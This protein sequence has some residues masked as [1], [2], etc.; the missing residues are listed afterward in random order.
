MRV[1]VRTAVLT[2][3]L[4]AAGVV[5]ALA[6][7][8][9]TFAVLPFQVNGPASY[10]H[11][12]R[13]IP[14]MLTSRLY[15]KDHFVAVD[16]SAYE[17]IAVPASSAEAATALQKVGVDYLVYGSTTIIGD[18]SSVDVHVVGSDGTSWPR[19]AS[20][21]VDQMI[22]TLRNLAEAINSEVF[23]RADAA[24]DVA[25]PNMVNQMNPVIQQNQ[26]TQDQQVFLN[27]QFRYAGDSEEGNR[28][29]SNTLS[30]AA[31]GM[32]VEDL[33]GNG[34]NEVILL[35]ERE[36]QVYSFT[37][38][39][40][41][42]LASYSAPMRFT[43]LTVRTVDLN[44]DGIMEIVV[45][46]VDTVQAPYSFILNFQNNALSVVAD[47][48]KYLLNVV[49]MPPDY[50]P[51]LIGQETSRG[52]DMWREPVHEMMPMGGTYEKG[53]RV[54]LPP[55]A[56]VYNFAWLPPSKSEDAKLVMVEPT[57]ERL[58]VFSEKLA[59][60]AET[61]ESYSGATIGLVQDQSFGSFGKDSY[62]M[63]SKYYIPMPMLTVDLDKEGRHELI[64]NKPISVAAQFFDNYRFY[65]QGEI[66][67]LYWDGVGLGLQWKTRRIK[68]S[69]VGY[70]IKDLNNDGIKDLVVC[71]NTHPGNVGFKQRKTMLLA[72]PL[73]LSQTGATEAH[74]E[75]S[76]EE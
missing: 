11:L 46:A 21:K 40:L 8:A 68:G 57:G 66:H 41:E 28:L 39:R 17:G 25:Q 5:S 34:K 3:L 55:G 6:D 71:I 74:R 33:N 13:A 23:K 12:E 54:T 10:K 44:R 4:L 16:Q 9:K 59:R 7:G 38:G 2:C 14:Q 70:D 35:T 20:S 31:H 26:L 15:W 75:F 30:I 22:P 50:M 36:V 60:L 45:S 62:L 47:K 24:A 72:F 67:S 18:E 64:V 42:P 61:P 32:A 49:R 65:P 76:D 51:V 43:L 63:G 53:R 19:S 1:F 37:N 27:P 52:N 56:N 58:R 29:R 73:D 69:V 48:I